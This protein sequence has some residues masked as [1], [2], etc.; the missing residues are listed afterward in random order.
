MEGSGHM[1]AIWDLIKNTLFLETMDNT[2]GS[3]TCHCTS[4]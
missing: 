4:F 2:G 1:G 3:V